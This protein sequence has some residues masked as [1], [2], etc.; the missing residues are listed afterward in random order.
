MGRP[1][2]GAGPGAGPDDSFMADPAFSEAQQAMERGDLDS[3]AAAFEKV[4]AASPGHPV[5]AMGLAQVGLIKRVGSYDQAQAQRDAAARPGDPDAQAR[6]ADI[7]VAT[8]RAEAGFDR[9]LGTVRRTSGEERDRAR[10]HLLSLFEV[11][12][13]KDPQVAKARAKLSSLLF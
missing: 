6:V 12:P 1:G 8:G 13:P 10:V 4:L 9:L 7:E 3:A 5:A 11:F 2:P